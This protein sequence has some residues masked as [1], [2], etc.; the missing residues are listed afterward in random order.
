MISFLTDTPAPI[1]TPDPDCGFIITARGRPVVDAVILTVAV[2]HPAACFIEYKLG[3]DREDLLLGACLKLR[4]FLDQLAEAY[5][6]T[7]GQPLT[8]ARRFALAQRL[9]SLAQQALP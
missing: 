1:G 2:D 4:P 5:E 9:L 7:H 3:L 6:S 8:S